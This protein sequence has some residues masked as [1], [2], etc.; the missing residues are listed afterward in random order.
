MGFDDSP[1]ETFTREQLSRFHHAVATLAVRPLLRHLCHSGGC[2]DTPEARFDAGLGTGTPVLED[3]VDRRP[4]KFT[5]KLGRSGLTAANAVDLEVARRQAAVR[6]DKCP[7][8][9]RREFRPS[10]HLLPASGPAHLFGFPLALPRGGRL[11][12]AAECS[13]FRGPIWTS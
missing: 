9:G 7:R 1:G 3:C 12:S 2:P 6:T 4:F 5:I 11:P 8:H 13:K 10:G